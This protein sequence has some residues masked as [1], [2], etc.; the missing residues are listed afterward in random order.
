MIIRVLTSLLY[1]S[2]PSELG[3]DTNLPT[4]KIIRYTLSHF[5]CTSKGYFPRRILLKTH[6]WPSRQ[7]NQNKNSAE[8]FSGNQSCQ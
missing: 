5:Y 6:N 3:G 1:E 4:K 2:S 8:I 7:N